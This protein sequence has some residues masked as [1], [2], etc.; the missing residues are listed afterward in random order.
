VRLDASPV[1]G[2]F[3]FCTSPGA[4]DAAGDAVLHSHV[5]LLSFLSGFGHSRHVVGAQ[6]VGYNVD[7]EILWYSL[8][9]MADLMGLVRD[10]RC[11][12]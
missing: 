12:E 2:G 4:H 8:S 10:K 3:P 9:A 1:T 11:G 5:R 6:C 7:G